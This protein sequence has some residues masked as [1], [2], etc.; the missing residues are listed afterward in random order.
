MG[1]STC[2]IQ[3]QKKAERE[4]ERELQI[5]LTN[6]VPVE[7][8]EGSC[9]ED[10]LREAGSGIDAPTEVNP[11]PASGHAVQ[12]LG[13]P[14]VGRDAEPRHPRGGAHQLGHLLVQCEP[15]HQVPQPHLQWKR[16]P[17]ENVKTSG[18]IGRIA[19]GRRPRGSCRQ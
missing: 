9:G 3:Q 1:E 19:G 18:G 12:R 2:P 6:L 16:L 7:D 8:I 10:D 5:H 13:P 15:R 4:R 11:S 14:L 17:A